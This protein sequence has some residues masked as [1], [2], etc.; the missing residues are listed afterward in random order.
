M[1]NNE[2]IVKSWVFDQLADLALAKSIIAQLQTQI[3]DKDKRIAELEQAADAAHAS[4][5]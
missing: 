4:N 3:A 2:S 5:P 1:N